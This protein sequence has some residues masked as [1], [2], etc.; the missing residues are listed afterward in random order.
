MQSENNTDNEQASMGSPNQE[1]DGSG[2]ENASASDVLRGISIAA[3]QAGSGSRSKERLLAQLEESARDSG[4]WIEDSVN[5]LSDLKVNVGGENE[6]YKSEDGTYAI[7][8]NDF[9]F[10]RDDA[11]NF[12]DFLNRLESFNELF[13]EIALQVVG[14]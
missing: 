12:E 2:R 5:E 13:P 9:A 1:G 7:K 11:T 8:L 4:Y 6:V 10:L 3:A 14:Y